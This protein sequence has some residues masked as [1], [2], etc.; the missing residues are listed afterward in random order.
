MKTMKTLLPR[1]MMML[2]K[3]GILL[4]AHKTLGAIE[5]VEKDLTT[6][7]KNLE[8][9][10]G[11]IDAVNEARIVIQDTAQKTQANIEYRLA[12]L[13][14]MALASVFD[15]PYEFV[16]AFQQKRNQTEAELLFSRGGEL[17]S[18][19]ESSGGGAVDIAS[20]ALRLVFLSLST[21]RKVLVL[22]EPFKYVSVDKQP[23]CSEMLKQL[24]EKLGIQIIM[25]SHL[26]EIIT[27]ADNIIKIDKGA[28]V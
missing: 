4:K 9:V 5:Q 7:K 1:K 8:A 2:E 11:K 18:P 10:Q 20:F 28:V 27:A 25:V 16:V 17:F 3:Q 13:V 19:M 14:S 6:L 23:A 12:S 15:D 24:S 26:P 21:A 22:D